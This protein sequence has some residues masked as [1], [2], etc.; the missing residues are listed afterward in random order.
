MAFLELRTPRD[1]L[2]KAKREH[3]RLSSNVNVDNAFNF[4]VTA[5]HIRDYIE[6]NGAVARID[7]DNFC[8][9]PDMLDC[10]DLCNKAKH[11]RLTR[12]RPDPVTHR[13][14][15]AMGGSPTNTQAT[16]SNGRWELWS[17][18]RHIDIQHLADRVLDLWDQFFLDHGL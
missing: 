8:A 5:Y 18:E 1:M 15:G 10:G 12:S 17:N 2:D 16:N 14:S 6:K 4:F 7:V 9:L 13:W 11:L 3:E